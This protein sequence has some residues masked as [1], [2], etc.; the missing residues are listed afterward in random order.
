MTGEGRDVKSCENNEGRIIN[1]NILYKLQRVSPSF[2]GVGFQ[3]SALL[4][5]QAN[6][7]T[8]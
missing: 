4:L 7:I 1:Y 3:L 5:E 6:A 2:E 8:I